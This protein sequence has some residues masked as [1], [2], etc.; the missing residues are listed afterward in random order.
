MY[1]YSVAQSCSTLCFFLDC[2]LLC[3]WNSLGKNTGGGSHSFLQG[4]FPNQG[5]TFKTDWIS[6]ITGR[7]FTIWATREAPRPQYS[8]ICGT[9]EQRTELPGIRLS[10]SILENP[11]T[12]KWG[13]RYIYPQD[14]PL[15]SKTTPTG[16]EWLKCS[17]TCWRYLLNLALRCSRGRQSRRRS[18]RQSLRSARDGD[19]WV[20]GRRKAKRATRV[21]ERHPFQKHGRTWASYNVLL[22]TTDN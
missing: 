16:S 18:L 10:I 11:N 21:W 9:G 7:F 13:S 22:F 12:R 2:S 8:M 15:V 19:W 6:C 3:P 5:S 14:Q 17:R 20:A 4:I 1:V